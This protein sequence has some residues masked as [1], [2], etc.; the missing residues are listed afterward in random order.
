M[1]DEKPR[2]VIFFLC[3]YLPSPKEIF[4]LNKEKVG[5]VSNAELH[6]AIKIQKARK[7]TIKA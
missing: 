2:Y 7:V 6:Y 3:R 4:M 1:R 5:S